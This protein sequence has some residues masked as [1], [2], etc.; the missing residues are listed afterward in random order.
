MLCQGCVLSLRFGPM[1]LFNVAGME[2]LVGETIGRLP[3]E[4]LSVSGRL[5]SRFHERHVKARVCPW[6]HVFPLTSDLTCIRAAY[7]AA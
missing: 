7:G 5:S 1:G 2:E 6:Y 3:R 4:G